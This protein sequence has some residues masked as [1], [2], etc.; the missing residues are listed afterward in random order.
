[1][2]KTLV[3]IICLSLAF[4]LF[5]DEKQDSNFHFEASIGAGLQFGILTENFY[6]E[7]PENG[8]ETSENDLYRVSWLNW[9]TLPLCFA[10]LNVTASYDFSR[11]HSI[12]FEPFISIGIPGNTGCMED[13]D[14]L[15]DDGRITDFSHH[16]SY[17]DLF[18]DTGFYADYTFLAGFGI[19]IGFEFQNVKFRAQNGYSQH[20]TTGNHT[21]GYWSPDMLHTCEYEG[22]TVITYDFFSFYWKPGIVWRH[23]FSNRFRLGLDAWLYLYRY[24][25]T[26]DKHYT[27]SPNV[28][29]EYY[30]DIV[31]AWFSGVDARAT[32]NYAFTEHFSL[33][34][35]VAG[36]YIP[37]AYDDD[38]TGEPP[39]CTRNIGYKGGFY[40]WSVS[41]TVSAVLQ[42]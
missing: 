26:L 33:A 38:Y 12:S 42:F 41:G 1:M 24:N 28:P 39:N 16:D 7:T 27:F 8:E 31:E 11:N 29:S 6:H 19:G 20:N 4:S 10:T 32:V 25:H 18:L 9:E 22:N 36:T 2:K 23:D 35:R 40:A 21:A 34:L 30:T 5:A 3:I 15:L 13:F 37:E 14:A 17:T